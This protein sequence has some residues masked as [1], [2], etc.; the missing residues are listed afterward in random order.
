MSPLLYREFFGPLYMVVFSMTIFP[1]GPL[2][3]AHRYLDSITF[4][5]RHQELRP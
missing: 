3:F 1:D 2:H 5:G 4:I